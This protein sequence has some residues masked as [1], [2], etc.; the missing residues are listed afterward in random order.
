MIHCQYFLPGYECT[1]TKEFLFLWIH[2]V[3]PITKCMFSLHTVLYGTLLVGEKQVGSLLTPFISTIKHAYHP[4][5]S[6]DCSLVNNP[7][8]QSFRVSLTCPSVL[9]P[10]TLC[11]YCIF[12]QVLTKKDVL[13]IMWRISI[14]S[15]REVWTADTHTGAQTFFQESWKMTNWKLPC[16]S[17]K[18]L[19]KVEKE[20]KFSLYTFKA[21]SRA[22]YSFPFCIMQY[23]D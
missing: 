21:I 8:W 14:H 16:N 2:S 5:N 19:A 17:K 15:R 22:R 3:V 9:L 23:V 6:V 7:A 11:Q 12:Q 10:E 18:H 1:V 4:K 13:W 20:M